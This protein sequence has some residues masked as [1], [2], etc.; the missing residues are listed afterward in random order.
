MPTDRRHA[1]YDDQGLIGYSDY[2]WEEEMVVGE[3]DGKLK[4]AVAP[5]ATPQEASRAI[6]AEKIR[7]D[8]I[9]A[10]VS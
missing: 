9:R 2:F 1:I 3:F 10:R 4:Y 8:R 7:E 5:G 6:I